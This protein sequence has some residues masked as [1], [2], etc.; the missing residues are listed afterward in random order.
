[1]LTA[2]LAGLVA[3]ATATIDEVA[4]RRGRGSG[5]RYVALLVKHDAPPRPLP[6]GQ[7]LL[8]PASCVA[9]EAPR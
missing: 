8:F 5:S 2:L 7:V 3:T 1:M 9:L 4:P 6:P